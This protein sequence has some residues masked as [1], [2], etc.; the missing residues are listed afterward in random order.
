MAAARRLADDAILK[1]LVTDGA[2]VK[3]VAH[4]GRTIP[5]RL[6]TALQARDPVCVVPGCEV[7]RGLEIDHRVP[8]AEGGSTTLDNL[9]RLCGWHHYLKSHR[10]HRLAGGPGRWSWSG[11]VGS[12]GGE[13]EGRAQPYTPPP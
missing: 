7:S 8:L 13:G 5:A 12:L 6:R 10:G 11:P 3:A 1:V 4:A 9:A 2:D